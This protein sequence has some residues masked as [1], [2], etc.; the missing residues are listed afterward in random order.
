M[1]Y[2]PRT[3]RAMTDPEGLVT[4]EVVHA[5]TDLQIS[6]LRD[7]TPQASALVATFR[8]QLEAYFA[9]NPYFAESLVP[10][11]A[12]PG[13]PA[14]VRAMADTAR[15]AGVGPMASVAGAMAE[16]VAR[17]LDPESSEVI[18]ENGGDLYLIS[19]FE[20]RVLLEAGDSPLSG[21]VG[22]L[23]E[24]G[25]MPVAVCT[26]SAKVGPSLSFGSAHAATVVARSGALADAAAS[27]A[28]NLVHG[29][30]D[31]ER[32]LARVKEIPGVL[33]AVVIADDTI[34]AVGGVSLFKV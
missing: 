14:I 13:A 34:G 18:V 29:P 19:R 1:T 10:V 12:S 31:I 30:D 11:D 16:A 4:F 21:H 20:R 22:L 7:L 23:L 6:A 17:G 5:E 25:M 32:A 15:T 9:A 28:G 3:Y 8:E 2:E 24:P 27:V 33:G 26:S